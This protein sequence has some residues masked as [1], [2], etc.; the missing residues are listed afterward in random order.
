V[1]GRQRIRAAVS[2]QGSM[3]FQFGKFDEA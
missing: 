1:L 2:S 3:R